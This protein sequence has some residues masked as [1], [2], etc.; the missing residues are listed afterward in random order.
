MREL[1]SLMDETKERLSYVTC[2][3]LVLTSTV[4]NVVPPE[5][6][7]YILNHIQSA[8]KDSTCFETLTMLRRWILIKTQLLHKRHSLYKQ[9]LPKKVHERI[10]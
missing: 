9:Q 6:S 4:D 3:A 5:N 1:L 8:E 2:P 10:F 7:A